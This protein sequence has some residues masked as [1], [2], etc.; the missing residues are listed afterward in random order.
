M[1]QLKL[2]FDSDKVSMEELKKDTF[3]FNANSFH[4]HL[5]N[6]KTMPR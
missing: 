1:R 4:F 3:I 6:E 5:D 2:R